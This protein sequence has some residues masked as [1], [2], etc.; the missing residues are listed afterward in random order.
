MVKHYIYK[1]GNVY[2]LSGNVTRVAESICA[3]AYST[4]WRPYS[5]TVHLPY[6]RSDIRNQ[7]EKNFLHHTLHWLCA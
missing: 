3:S 6:S 4:R 1:H 5:C 2:Q 7:R